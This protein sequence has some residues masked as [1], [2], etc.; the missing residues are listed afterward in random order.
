M[1]LDPRSRGRR[2]VVSDGQ[3]GFE[4]PHPRVLRHP[5][6]QHGLALN[7]RLDCVVSL[8][9]NN[10][11]AESVGALRSRASSDRGAGALHCIEA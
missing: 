4:P 2:R 11:W 1:L 5:R 10:G 7:K 9:S 6:Q 3:F 8:A